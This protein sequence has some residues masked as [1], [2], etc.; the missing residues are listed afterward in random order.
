MDQ[1]AD[2][3]GYMDPG[4]GSMLA[5]VVVAGTAGVAVAVKMGWRRASARIR[6]K[7]HSVVAGNRNGDKDCSA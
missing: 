3:F 7:P 6:G 5:Q 1:E 4:S 2:V